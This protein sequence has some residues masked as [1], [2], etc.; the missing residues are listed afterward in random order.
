[1]KSTELYAL[2]R[3]DLGSWFKSADFK[4]AKGFLSWSRSRGGA[5]TVVWFQASQ[6]GW[7]AFAG[8]KF[9]VEFQRSAEPVP[10][11]HPARR[12]RMAGLLSATAREEMRALN[13]SVIASLTPPP[14][15]HHALHVSE[16]VTVWY[17]KKFVLDALPYSDRDDVWLRYAAPD[18]VREWSRFLLEQLPACV[19][20]VESWA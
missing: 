14:D 6:D 16:S 13:N 9:V 3:S 2:L 7:D 20:S 8:S 10:G 18:H 12:M 17:R 4:R 11:A 15:S 19:A 1:M 5:S